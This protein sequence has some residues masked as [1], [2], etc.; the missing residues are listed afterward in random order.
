VG[1][2][3]PAT[4]ARFI[5]AARLSDGPFLGIG[6]RRIQSDEPLGT[7]AVHAS[8]GLEMAPIT[9]EEGLHVLKTIFAF[10]Q[11]TKTG[12]VQRV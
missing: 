5:L 7:R 11:A 8:A 2:N 6:P 3:L 9:G 10:Y 1:I 12:R 4:Y